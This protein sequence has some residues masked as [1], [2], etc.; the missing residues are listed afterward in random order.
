MNNQYQS[1]SFQSSFISTQ[2]QSTNYTGVLT[3]SGLTDYEGA[4]SV[5][6]KILETYDRDRNGNIDTI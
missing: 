5:A 3:N 4:K 2:Q 6:R 1:T